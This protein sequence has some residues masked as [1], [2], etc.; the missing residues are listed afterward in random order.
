MNQ[1]LKTTAILSSILTILFLSCTV[2]EEPGPLATEERVLSAFD[3][4]HVETIG[5]VNLHIAQEY[6]VMI[7]TNANVLDDIILSI[8]DEELYIKL[9]GKHKEID[10]LEFDVYAP[11]FTLIRLDGVAIIRSNDLLAVNELRVVQ[12]GVGNI[13]LSDIDVQRVYF[14]LDEV[15]DVEVKGTADD[16]IAEHSGVGNLRL[17]ELTGRDGDLNLSGTGNIDINVTDELKINLSGVGDIRYMGSPS[18]TVNHTGVGKIV[19]IN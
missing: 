9:T 10:Q 12:D 8:S 13:Y 4:V 3:G 7:N 17:F 11:E 15:G 5:K 19:K 1:G 6:R 16:I 2:G 18:M 14:D